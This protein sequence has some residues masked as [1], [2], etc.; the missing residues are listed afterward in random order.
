MAVSQAAHHVTPAITNGHALA[1]CRVLHGICIRLRPRI[2]DT[3]DQLALVTDGCLFL[4]KC[5]RDDVAGVIGNRPLYVHFTQ[6][7]IYIEVLTEGIDAVPVEFGSGSPWPAPCGN[8]PLTPQSEGADVRSLQVV[9]TVISYSQL[10][11]ILLMPGQAQ[12][13]VAGQRRH[14]ASLILKVCKRPSLIDRTAQLIACRRTPPALCEDCLVHTPGIVLG[15]VLH[16]RD[17]S[18]VGSNVVRDLDVCITL[19]VAGP[20]LVAGTASGM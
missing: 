9:A 16:S 8:V 3:S 15:D 5:I 20:G 2:A 12:R 17:E 7:P 4:H 14:V 13:H 6:R 19:V 11:F 18:P 10:F 1:R